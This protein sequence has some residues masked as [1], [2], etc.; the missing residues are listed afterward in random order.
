MNV[1]YKRSG[2][3]VMYNV[4]DL[5]ELI[6]YIDIDIDVGIEAEEFLYGYL[7]ES[8]KPEEFIYDMQYSDNTFS[9]SEEFMYDMLYTDNTFFHT[10]EFLY[11]LL[12]DSNRV[13]SIDL[14]FVSDYGIDIVLSEVELDYTMELELI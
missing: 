14:D 9:H 7:Y 10:E 3:K 11:T 4:D 13:R 6:S 8:D 2:T 5:L 12:Y 1:Y